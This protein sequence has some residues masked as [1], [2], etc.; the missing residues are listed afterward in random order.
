MSRPK[1][2]WLQTPGYKT[3]SGL[4]DE[5]AHCLR[6]CVGAPWKTSRLRGPQSRHLSSH[7]P[8]D[9]W[10]TIPM[11]SEWLSAVSISALHKDG[12]SKS[13][14]TSWSLFIGSLFFWCKFCRYP[15]IATF[16]AD[17]T[18]IVTDTRNMWHQNWKKVSYEIWTCR[19]ISADKKRI[20]HCKLGLYSWAVTQLKFWNAV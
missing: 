6:L 4:C 12:K 15:S 19:F 18:Q 5:I 13:L 1:T 11:E 14:I 7:K 9:C 3:W 17:E 2:P 8:L 20:L 10:Q 16:P